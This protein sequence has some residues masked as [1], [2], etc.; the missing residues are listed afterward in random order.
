MSHLNDRAKDTLYETITHILSSDKVSFRKK[1]FL[2]SKLSP[3]KNSIKYFTSPKSTAEGRRRRV[4][5][6]GGSPMSYVLGTAIPL[7]V[8]LFA[9]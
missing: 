6:M 2:S 5:Q 4:V 1:K 7:F 8:N 9:E 3:F